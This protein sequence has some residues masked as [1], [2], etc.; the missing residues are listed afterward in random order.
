MK[1]LQRKFYPDIRQQDPIALFLREV[2]EHV[3]AVATVLDVGAGAGDRNRYDFKGRVRQM[4][5]TDLDPRV[6]ENPL[7]D[8]GRICDGKTLPFDPG[9]VDLAFS[10]YV[11]EHIAAPREFTG[12]IFRVLR[13]GGK[14]FALSP[15]KFHYVPFIAGLTPTA[16]HKWVNRKRGR[17][18]ED[19]FPTYYRLNTRKVARDVFEKSGLKV[20]DI[21]PFEVEP[22][23]LQFNSL[24]YLGGVAYERVV[25]RFSLLQDFRVNIISSYV[26]PEGNR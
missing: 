22:K 4:L 18:D 13:P 24:A 10:I 5:G 26:K 21:R 25:N 19:T 8:E 7:L 16:F 20:L 11:H 12:E 2:E 17:P 6:L 23:Y 14:Y 15:N 1:N 3:D 9:S